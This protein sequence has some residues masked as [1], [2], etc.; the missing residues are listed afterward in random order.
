MSDGTK[1]TAKMRTISLGDDFGVVAV[2]ANGVRVEIGANGVV[3]A[4]KGRRAIQVIGAGTDEAAALRPGLF[5]PGK[6]VFLGARD[7]TDRDGMRLGNFNFFAAPYDLGLDAQGRGRKIVGT[8]NQAAGAVV[9]IRNLL[10]HDGGGWMS[11]AAWH[12]AL[13]E[14]QYKGEWIL[15]PWDILH[16]ALYPLKNE[17]TLKDTLTD[18]GGSGYAHW[19]WSCTEHRDNPA[20]VYDVD[21]TDGHDGWGHKDYISLSSRVVRAELN[22]LAL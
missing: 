6:G 7:V 11:E 21:F 17:G 2:E 3:R 19:Y 22:H 5:V 14:G 10:G 1:I 12:D 13:R 18:K 16:E 8:F 9:G 20:I 15:P 4:Y